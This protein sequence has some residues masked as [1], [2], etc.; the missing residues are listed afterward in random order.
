MRLDHQ[1]MIVYILV[2]CVLTAIRIGDAHAAPDKEDNLQIEYHKPEIHPAEHHLDGSMIER[3]R[4]DS[5]FNYP[6]PRVQRAGFLQL[7]LS[8]VFQWLAEKMGKPVAIFL[9]ILLAALLLSSVL[10][11]LYTVFRG[12]RQMTFY[13]ADRE[14]ISYEVQREDI[15]QMDFGEEIQRALEDKD[16]KKALRILYLSTLKRMTDA[17]LIDWAGWK[18]NRDYIYELKDVG[19]KDKFS[20]LSMYYEYIWYGNFE[21]DKNKFD[22]FQSINLTLEALIR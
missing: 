19:L 4:S 1:K 18:T 10:L 21:I 16:Y 14:G 12:E 22:E 8:R 17:H 15:H 6:A 9:M 3:Y 2:S 11:L 5:N 13:K 7:L 20:D